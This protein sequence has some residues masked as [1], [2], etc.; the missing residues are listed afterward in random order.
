MRL[1]VMW[2]QSPDL[3]LLPGSLFLPLGGLD[4]LHSSSSVWHDHATPSA[5]SKRQDP[6][7]WVLG[8]HSSRIQSPISSMDLGT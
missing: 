1:W 6:S 2:A 8:Q 7:D 4:E 5:A 3:D